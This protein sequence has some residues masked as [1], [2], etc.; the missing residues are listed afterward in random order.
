MNQFLERFQGN[1]VRGSS[2]TDASQDYSG[3]ALAERLHHR[4]LI[5]AAVRVPFACHCSQI[6]TFRS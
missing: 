2:P 6:L 5:A 1:I 3:Q 4:I